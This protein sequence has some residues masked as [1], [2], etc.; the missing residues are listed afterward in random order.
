MSVEIPK[1]NVPVGIYL[2]S[3]FAI[4]VAEYFDLRI[5]FWAGMATGIV[6]FI[7][8]VICLWTYTGNYVRKKTK[9]N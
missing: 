5:T 9:T 7:S 4:G 1:I 2:I 6:S 8:I 3:I